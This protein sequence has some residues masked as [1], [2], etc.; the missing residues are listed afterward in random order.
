MTD[1][2]F[3]RNLY[4][5]RSKAQLTQQELADKICVSRTAIARYERGYDSPSLNTLGR[6]ADALGCT[7]TDLVSEAAK[8]KEARV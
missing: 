3:E 1:T 7:V 4:Y 8:T 5:F 6:L 2:A